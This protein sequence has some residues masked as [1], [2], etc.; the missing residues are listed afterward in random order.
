MKKRGKKSSKQNKNLNASFLLIRYVL[1]IV[2]GLFLSVFYKILFY[3]TVYPVY[4]ILKLFYEVT[5]KASSIF[6]GNVEIQI[7]NACV[8]GSAYYLL[9]ILNLTTPMNLKKRVKTIIFSLLALLI[10]NIL[11]IVIFSSL[12]VE[13]FTFFDI[14]HKLVW[15]VMSIILVVGIWFATVKIYKIKEIPVYSDVK[16]LYNKKL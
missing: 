4:Y 12:Y 7:V 6:I 14:T 13:N 1:L 10:L 16:K 9:L 8:A 2:F 11:R 15:Y 3:I 5:I